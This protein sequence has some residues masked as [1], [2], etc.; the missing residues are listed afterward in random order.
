M[1]VHVS[2][3]MLQPILQEPHTGRVQLRVVHVH[4]MRRKLH[5]SDIFCM[6]VKMHSILKQHM[7]ARLC[8]KFYICFV[9]QGSSKGNAN[10]QNLKYL[11]KWAARKHSR[12]RVMFQV[13]THKCM[14]VN[15]TT[16][17]YNFLRS[18]TWE[19]FIRKANPVL[20]KLSASNSQRPRSCMSV[21]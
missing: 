8:L 18:S 7:H 13:S 17:L 14:L 16:Y 12:K 2:L 19:R 9:S 10:R 5:S 15:G 3:C 21:F 11:E 6:H 1:C 4:K 20:S